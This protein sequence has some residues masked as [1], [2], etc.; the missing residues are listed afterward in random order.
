MDRRRFF[1]L[2]VGG[3]VTAATLGFPR[4]A[5]AQSYV[6]TDEQ[7]FKYENPQNSVTYELQLLMAGVRNFATASDDLKQ[8]NAWSTQPVLAPDEPG[9]TNRTKYRYRISRVQPHPSIDGAYNVTLTCLNESGEPTPAGI[10]FKQDLEVLIV[11]N[12]HAI[13][14]SPVTGTK[15]KMIKMEPPEEDFYTVPGCFLTTACVHHK[16]LAD[17]G[18]ELNTLRAFREEYMRP[19][20]DGQALLDRYYVDGP[21]ILRA[22]E[23]QAN[24]GAYYEHMYQHLVR[25]SLALIEQHQKAEAMAYYRDYVLAIKSHLRLG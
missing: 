10:F 3:M 14:E 4:Y 20:S 24:P 15:Y 6:D 11:P 1:Q 22:V 19:L 16:G 23:Q 8:A 7:F 5:K 21:A 12:S 2:G 18:V 9:K 17:D 13:I 25:P